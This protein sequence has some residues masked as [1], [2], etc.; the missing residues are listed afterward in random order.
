MKDKYVTALI[1]TALVGLAGLGARDVFAG[2]CNDYHI[3][4]GRSGQVV[5]VGPDAATDQPGVGR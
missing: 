3:D 1:L 4:P 2:A 5:P